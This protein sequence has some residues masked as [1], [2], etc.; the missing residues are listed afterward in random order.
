MVKWLSVVLILALAACN[1]SRITPQLS[2]GANNRSEITPQVIQGYGEHLWTVFPDA[3]AVAFGQVAADN[4]GNIY[5]CGKEGIDRINYSGKVVSTTYEGPYGFP[6]SACSAF[7]TTRDGSIW[8][9]SFEIKHNAFLYRLLPNGSQHQYDQGFPAS[10]LGSL[11]AGFGSDL[12]YVDGAGVHHFNYVTGTVQNFAVPAFY[13]TSPY[14]EITK[15]S[16]GNVWVLSLKGVGRYTP[17]GT[18][19]WFNNL[20]PNSGQAGVILGPNGHLFTIGQNCVSYEI[21]MSGEVVGHTS[22]GG[23]NCS[24]QLLVTQGALW[25]VACNPSSVINVIEW[26]VLLPGRPVTRTTVPNS[27]WGSCYPSQPDGGAVGSD[28]NL[29]FNMQNGDIGVRIL[30]SITVT[31]YVSL[32]TFTAIGQFLT[33]TVRE[34]N[35]SGAWTANTNNPAV[36]RVVRWLSKTQ[37]QIESTGAGNG[38]IIIRDNK[39]NYFNY[40]V[41][42]Q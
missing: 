31:P 20:P 12:W 27:L 2:P 42:V 33:L 22:L 21:T 5:V 14:L 28:G 41:A 30:D 4:S 18:M 11:T 6:A 8:G 19:K 9:E 38:R 26:H 25:D 17:T 13:R 16:D 35:Y 37:V 36:V 7:A 34:S 10:G 32:Y 29:Y 40:F 23:T 15:G 1:A 3:N 39:N 24:P